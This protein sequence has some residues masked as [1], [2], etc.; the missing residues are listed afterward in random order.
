MYFFCNYIFFT[1]SH[2]TALSHMFVLNFTK[3]AIIKNKATNSILDFI[4]WH[5]KK[6][7]ILG[8]SKVSDGAGSR[9][10]SYLPCTQQDPGSVNIDRSSSGRICIQAPDGS[11]LS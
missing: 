7:H 10:R 5:C 2:E 4:F 3:L 1:I 8:F 11:S 9:G 6:S